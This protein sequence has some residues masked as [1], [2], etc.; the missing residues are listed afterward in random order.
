MDV[1]GT[2]EPAFASVRDA[3]AGNFREGQEGLPELGASFAAYVNGEPVVNIWGGYADKEK[4]VPWARDALACVYS[5]GKAVCAF[6]IARA[7]SAGRLDYDAPVARYWPE[8]AAN[9]KAAVTVA[10]ALSHQAGLCGFADE[11]DPADWL[12]WELIAG[13][14]AAM[15]PLWPLPSAEGGVSGYH[16]QTAGFIAGELV[17]RVEGRSIGCILR[18]DYFE[19]RGLDVHCGIGSEVAA[20]A[21]FMPKP[22][23][24]PDLGE[25]NEFTKIAF[26]KPW[27]SPARVAREAWMAAEL[28]ASNMH[29][30]ARGLAG[31]V[32][33]LACDGEG[34]PG[35]DAQTIAAVLRPRVSGPDFVLPFDLMW[36]AGLMANTDG[37]FGPSATAFGHAGFGGSCVVVDPARRLSA[38]YVM[39][40]MSPSLVGDPRAKRLLNALYAAF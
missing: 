12:D 29:A 40:R 25:L 19:A 33:P 17:H 36:A 27:S 23:R 34:E 22:P 31:L 5:S 6:L 35:L 16:P 26:L 28:P 9:G 1:Q 30:T 20:R 10:E 15:A 3:F 37:Q 24:P 13:R 21:V 4:S 8:F 14:L 2:F 7:V 39:N 38:A 32:H 11:M 18:E